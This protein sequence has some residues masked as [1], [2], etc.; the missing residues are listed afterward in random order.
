MNTVPLP[1]LVTRS[2]PWSKNWPKKVM[3]GVEGHGQA[4][5][6]RDVRDEERL[7]RRAVRAGRRSPDSDPRVGRRGRDRRRVVGGLVHDQVA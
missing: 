1:P 4:G 3:H 5:V 2:R 6:R 7:E